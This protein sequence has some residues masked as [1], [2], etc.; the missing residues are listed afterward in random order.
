MRSATTNRR[1]KCLT[2]A[3]THRRAHLSRLK[4]LRAQLAMEV[5]AAVS[6]G[7]IHSVVR[8]HATAAVEKFL[9][10]LPSSRVRSMLVGVVRERAI[11]SL[12]NRK[13]TVRGACGTAADHC[14]GTA[15]SDGE[16]ACC[17]C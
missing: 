6:L 1:E 17:C 4:A 9:L 10:P 2:D 5:R 3:S 12:T 16:K 15:G 14:C 11:W 7:A 8:V 13:A